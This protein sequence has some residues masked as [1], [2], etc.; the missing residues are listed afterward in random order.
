MRVAVDAMG[1][2]AGPGPLVAGAART[3]RAEKG[4]RVVLVGPPEQLEPLLASCEGQHSRI[5][6]FP[7][8]QIITPEDHP[9]ASL[10]TKP[11][12]SLARCWQLLFERKVEAMVSA[13][14][15]GVLVAAGM[16]LGRFLPS[17]LKP[18]LAAVLPTLKGPAVV[19]DVAAN[20]EPTPAQLYQYGVMG[21]LYARQV[22]GAAS[23]SI[24]LLSVGSDVVRRFELARATLALFENSPLQPQFRG[25]LEAREAYRGEVNVIVSDG[26]V[27][28]MLLQLW[29]GAL[30]FVADAHGR[31]MGLE[32]AA[33]PS[34]PAVLRGA[35]LGVEG[36]C[37]TCR[38][39]VDAAAAEA[40]IR[41]PLHHAAVGLNG[42]IVKELEN[43]PLIRPH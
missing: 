6:I 23:A 17:V 16:R 9:T 38:P 34:D 40:A 39:D 25:Q 15:P 7:A 36:V 14:N 10:R 12:S 2:E 35:F 8:S 20:L 31:G 37:I 41:A 27:G 32:Q 28:A 33:T 19:I 21:A 29:K 1:S 30:A 22:L 11:D 42:L 5:E 4:L 26:F 3:V 13:G 18:G 24:G 43:G